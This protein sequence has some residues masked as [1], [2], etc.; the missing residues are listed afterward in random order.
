MSLFSPWCF[1][2]GTWSSEDSSTTER[3]DA[4]RRFDAIRQF[5]HERHADVAASWIGA[6]RVAGQ[7]LPRQHRYVCCREQPLRKCLV[8]AAGHARPEVEPGFRP[9]RMHHALQHGNER[10]EL[11]AI[12]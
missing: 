8:I 10:V 3:D 6:V 4:L 11:L 1:V 12:E 5:G 9:R 2:L 7:I